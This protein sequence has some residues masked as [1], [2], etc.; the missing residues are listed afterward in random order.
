MLYKNLTYEN[1]SIEFKEIY[2]KY[3]KD[4]TDISISEWADYIGRPMFLYLNNRGNLKGGFIIDINYLISMKLKSVHLLPTIEII[5]RDPSGFIGNQMFPDDNT[6]LSFLKRS[7]NPKIEPIRLDFVIS[8]FQTN[9]SVFTLYG[10]LNIED[11]TENVAYKGSSFNVLKNIA[12][13]MKLGFLTNINDTNDEM[14]W[15]N[16]GNYIS[17]FI[18][19]IT[20]NSYNGDNSFM[21]SFIDFFNRLNYIDIEQQLQQNTLDELTLWENYF[22]KNNNNEKTTPL[23]LT[24]HPNMILS[25]LYVEKYV[26]L[27]NSR[28]VNMDIGYKSKVYFYNK[29]EN[30]LI[31]NEINILNSIN[32]IYKNNLKTLDSNLN[33]KKY[34]LG[35][36]DNDNVHLNYL[37]ANKQN[38]INLK[39]LQ[40]LKINIVLP[41]ANMSIYRMQHVELI[42]YELE[43]FNHDIYLDETINKTDSYKINDK[44]SGS[45]L[46]TSINYIYI[47]KQMKQ[48]ITMV[49]RDI[50]IE[51][52]KEKLNEL[53]KNF[54]L[55]K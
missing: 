23:L 6:I 54:Y 32:D 3:L 14:T 25:N 20:L 16:P 11:R 24:N 1:S 34:Y 8:D 52:D 22:D 28:H 10:I 13:D 7:T 51:Y 2:I 21:I 42:I 30:R 55:K 47:K 27:N 29:T 4:R 36:M 53:T 26:I 9:D 33:V 44:L 17:Q 50:N 12:N 45:W 41:L 31:N 35:K 18:S 19:D 48:E 40:K 39:F 37:I 46:I 5:F 49:K 15:I 38:D 43:T